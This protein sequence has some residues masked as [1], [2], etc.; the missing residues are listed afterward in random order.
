MARE[1]PPI[2]KLAERV[3]LALE[4]AVQGFSRMHKYAIGAELRENA[5]E[6]WRAAQR[7]WRDSAGRGEHLSSLVERVDELKL[8]MQLAQQLRAFSGFAQFEAIAKPVSDLG[9]QCGGWQ[10]SHLSGQN[11]QTQAPAGR[12][13]ILSARGTSAEV[14]P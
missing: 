8:N 2:V 3:L 14:H 13:Q 11:R 6:V 12:A 9:R 1:A 10:K 7:A 4:Q 5:R